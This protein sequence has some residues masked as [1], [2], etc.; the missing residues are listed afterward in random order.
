MCFVYGSC[1]LYIYNT[2]YCTPM[3]L[4]ISIKI[5]SVF[6]LSQTKIPLLHLLTRRWIQIHYHLQFVVISHGFHVLRLRTQFLHKMHSSLWTDQFPSMLPKYD[7]GFIRFILILIE[8]QYANFRTLSHLLK[9]HG[10]AMSSQFLQLN[11]DVL[12]KPYTRTTV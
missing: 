6:I 11:S 10:I 3:S 5:D 4:V 9:L 12:H 7:K 2:N 8:T 1:S